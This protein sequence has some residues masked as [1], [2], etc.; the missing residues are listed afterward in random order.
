MAK[1]LRF[2]KKK[3]ARK[4][5]RREMDRGLNSVTRKYKNWIENG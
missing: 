3:F 5:H 1:F 4:N 2:I